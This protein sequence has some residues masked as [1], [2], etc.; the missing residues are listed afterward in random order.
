MPSVSDQGL[1]SDFGPGVSAE[2]QAS[3]GGSPMLGE[4]GKYHLFFS[5]FKSP[6]NATVPS[7]KWWYNTSV[8]AHAVSDAPDRGFVFKGEVLPPRGKM[9]FDGSTTHNP[10]VVKLADRSYALYFIG[11]NCHN[12]STHPDPNVS[13][14][15]PSVPPPSFSGPSS[16]A[17]R[18][19][20]YTKVAPNRLDPHHHTH[21]R[22]SRASP[23]RCGVTV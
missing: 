13:D 12:Y 7:I 20:R 23:C 9:F 15:P 1:I 2:K 16:V 10:T 4:D 5:W 3:W 6:D 8:V 22:P 17:A 11:L 18:Y 19:D 21:R 14:G